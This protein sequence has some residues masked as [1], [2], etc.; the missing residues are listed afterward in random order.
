M[1]RCE[2]LTA[3]YGRKAI[4]KDITWQTEPGNLTV[5]A[6]P[7]GSGKSTLLKSVMGQTRILEGRIFLDGVQASSWNARERA[8]RV[9]YVPQ[10]RSDSSLT[11]ARMVLHGRFPHIACPRHYTKED[12]DRVEQIL[13]RVGILNLKNRLI[14]EL[15]GGEKQKVYLSMALVQDAPLL[16]LDEPASFL[17]ISWQLELMDLLKELTGEG[18]TIAAVLHDLNHSLMYADRLVIMDRGTVAASGTPD[19]ILNLGILEQVFRLN[20]FSAAEADGKKH[21][22][23]RRQN[24]LYQSP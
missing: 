16:L 8:R 21:Y 18:R 12:E 7:N 5:I 6:G 14:P 3:G 11:V 1:I 2:H 19:E 17:D 22:W 23:F 13:D 9:A 10:S 15:S 24:P 4:I 20:I